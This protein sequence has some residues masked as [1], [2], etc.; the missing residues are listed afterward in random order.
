MQS[1]RKYS[2]SWASPVIKLLRSFVYAGRGVL[3][4]LWE[5]NFRIHIVAA[6]AVVY[7]GAKFYEFSRAE[8]AVLALTIGAVL[9]LEAVNTALEHLC[10]KTSPEHDP[11]IGKCKDC[12][13]GAVLLSA[14]A[15]LGV[16]AALF[17]DTERFAA[18]AEYFCGNIAALIALAA[19][20]ALA[21]V[22][23]FLPE[24]FKK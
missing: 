3:L 22:W 19:A 1:R 5:R 6:A 16:A 21:A 18:I 12:A 23:V 7:F 9:S 15:A 14:I 11:L 13:A 8:W 20:V 2:K 4:C 17:W 10:D 24:R